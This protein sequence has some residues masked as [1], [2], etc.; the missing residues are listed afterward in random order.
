MISKTLKNQSINSVTLSSNISKTNT[1]TG[2]KSATDS[3]WLTTSSTPQNIESNSRKSR[4]DGTNS[5]L[6][7]IRK[8]KPS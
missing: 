7:P 2:C 5:K 4:T 8:S 1:E 3:R 6:T